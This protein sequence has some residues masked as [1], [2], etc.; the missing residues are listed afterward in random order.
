MTDPLTPPRTGVPSTKSVRELVLE[1]DAE[2]I[3]GYWSFV[4]SEAPMTVS[5]TNLDFM[6]IG[7]FAKLVAEEIEEHVG[8]GTTQRTFSI[9]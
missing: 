9:Y 1:Y 2:D 6:R 7:A 5:S 3:D 4:P 8:R